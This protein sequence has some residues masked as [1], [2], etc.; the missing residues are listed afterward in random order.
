M[1]TILICLLTISSFSAWSQ[2]DTTSVNT[3][4]SKIIKHDGTELIGVILKNDEREV[5]LKTKTLGNVIIPKHT[6]K[7]IEKIKSSEVKVDGEVWPGNLLPSRYTITTNGLPVKKREGYLRVMPIGVD[8][9]F[10]ITDNWSIG[11]MTSWYGVPMIVTSKVSQSITQKVHVSAGFLYG[12]L[13]HGASFTGDPFFSYG[14]G[15][16][17]GNLTI[18]NEEK[19]LNFSAGY[20]FVH[21]PGWQNNVNVIESA[22]TTMFS[23]AGMARISKQALFVF[24]SMGI[25]VNGSPL[26]WINPAV[27]YMPKP[28]NIWQFGLSMAGFEDSFIPVPIPMISFTK[29]FLK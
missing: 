16:G 26:Y 11:G 3:Q 18:G 4:Y 27:R 13:L 5:L 1:R 24:D 15:I 21:Y 8:F 7:S 9:Q 17:F 12:N 14:G 20:G 19:N 10:P 22:G 28:S 6:I 25:L 29:V 2:T 23:V